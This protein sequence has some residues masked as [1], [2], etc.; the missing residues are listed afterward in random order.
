[1][2]WKLIDIEQET[3]HRF[4]NFFVLHYEISDD[5][6]SRPYSYFMASRHGKEELLVKARQYGRPDG[7]VLALYR[8]NQGN[9]E[10]L[11]TTQYRPP[12]GAYLTSFTAGLLDEG[13]TVEEAAIRE[14]YEEVGAKVSQVEVLAPASPSSSGLSDEL[15]AMALAKIET[16]EAPHLEENEDISYTFVPLS[17]LPAIL[18]DK[19]RIIPL[20][21][22]LTLL[23]LLRRFV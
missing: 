13:E 12:I 21:V 7:V 1:M 6:G 2:E 15:V 4:L 20:N 22:R 18:E 10:V 19:N 14:A 9:I 11:L 23:Y 5:Y 16:M 8:E 3:N 17:A